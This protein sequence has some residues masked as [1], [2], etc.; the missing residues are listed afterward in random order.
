MNNWDFQITIASLFKYGFSAFKNPT[1]MHLDQLM[2]MFLGNI[3]L[4]V[5]VRFF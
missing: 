1:F 3:G 5:N 4:E 2:K